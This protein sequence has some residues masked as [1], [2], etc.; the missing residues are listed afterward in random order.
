MESV[1][2][3]C[4]DSYMGVLIKIYAASDCQESEPETEPVPRDGTRHDGR[5]KKSQDGSK[6]VQSPHLRVAV[7]TTPRAGS[8]HL[9]IPKL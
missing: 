2:F 9:K 3:T 8:C 7:Q 6:E 1:A 4:Q 5:G